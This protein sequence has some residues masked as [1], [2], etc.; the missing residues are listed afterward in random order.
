MHGNKKVW[1]NGR[2]NSGLVNFVSESRLPL[3]QISPIYQNTTAKA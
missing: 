1:V 3:V 2:Q